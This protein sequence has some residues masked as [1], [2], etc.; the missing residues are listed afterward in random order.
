[1]NTSIPGKQIRSIFVWFHEKHHVTLCAEAFL[2]PHTDY[3]TL[4]LR[5]AE[6]QRV[7]VAPTRHKLK[8]L[9]RRAGNSGRPLSQNEYLSRATRTAG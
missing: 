1:M 6:L 4:S 3:E 9:T 8:S 7:K 5:E 2:H